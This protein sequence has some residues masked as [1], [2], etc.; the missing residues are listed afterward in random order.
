MHKSGLVELEAVLA[1][2][3]HRSFRAAARELDMSASALSNAVIA[4]EERLGI[5]LFNRTTRSVGLT[6]A[7][8]TFVEQVAPAVADINL[9]MEVVNQRRGSPKGTLRINAS[10]GAARRIL[11]PVIVDYLRRH[12]DMEVVIATDGR[13]VDIVA[14]GWDAGIRP[15]AVVPRDMVSVP[16]GDDV[17]FV[18]VGTPEYFAARDVPA[19][20]GDLARHECIRARMP[21]GALSSWEF[22]RDGKTETIDVPG[23]LTLDEPNVMLEAARS[24]FGL[25]YLADK[26]CADDLKTGR[27]V[28]VLGDWMPPAYDLCLYYPGR[29]H[30]PAGLRALVELIG[31]H[32]RRR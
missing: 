29:R 21:S 25:A 5:R 23:R 13:L 14:E 17:R 26:N 27:L 4:L 20:P 31:Q 28:Q 24:G 16:L 19:S 8:D 32:R 11:S 2:A 7:G 10:S 6:E 1:V 18:V 22:W 15:A 30:V 3:R 12:P 9:A